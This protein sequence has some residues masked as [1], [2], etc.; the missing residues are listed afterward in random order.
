ML[1]KLILGQLSGGYDETLKLTS[2]C[3]TALDHCER[4]TLCN[5]Y[6]EKVKRLCDP[7]SCDNQQKCMRSI[8]DFY[9]GIP[10]DFSL[11]IAFCICR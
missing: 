2:T 10:Q 11:E 3:H 4:N 5:R 9:R 8:Q 7:K 6:L 1:L